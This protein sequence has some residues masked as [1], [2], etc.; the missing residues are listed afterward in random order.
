[1]RPSSEPPQPP[2]PG[3]RG[4]RIAGRR[5]VITIFGVGG[6]VAG[7][8]ILIAVLLGGPSDADVACQQ[9]PLVCA[10]VRD[11]TAALNERDAGRVLTLVTDRGLRVKLQVESEEEL[12]RRL[13]D[14]AAAD[15]I[16][17]LRISSVTLVG[18]TAEVRTRFFRL[19]QQFDVIYQLIRIES[20]WLIDG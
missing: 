3:D 14:Q 7:V 5:V 15:R 11:Y 1:M 16:E 8:L 12:A 9:T 13:D 4:G 2:T 19:N 17:D 18:D 20:R 6:A 10:T